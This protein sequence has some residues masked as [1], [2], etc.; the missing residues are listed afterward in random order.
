M[1]DCIHGAISVN[2][3]FISAK[4]Q[5]IHSKKFPYGCSI[6]DS[7][8]PSTSSII[9]NVDRKGPQC[10]YGVKGKDLKWKGQS[11]NQTEGTRVKLAIELDK[12]TNTAKITITG[13]LI[14][15]M[16]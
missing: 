9:L 15:D 12:S 4:R 2:K 7:T 3:K 11:T 14:R 13:T 16:N 1:Q 6:I 10:E 8:E 5:E